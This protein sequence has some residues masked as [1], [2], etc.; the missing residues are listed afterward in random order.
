MT[1]LIKYIKENQFKF[2]LKNNQAM[3]DKNQK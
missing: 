3:N 2:D 1:T